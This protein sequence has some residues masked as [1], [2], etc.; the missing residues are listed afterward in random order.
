MEGGM[1]GWHGSCPS[2]D[3]ASVQ[4]SKARQASARQL[5]IADEGS[6]RSGKDRASGTHPLGRRQGILAAGA[7]GRFPDRTT[8]LYNYIH[9]HLQVSMFTGSVYVHGQCLCSHPSSTAPL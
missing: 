7:G 8:L 5:R 1:G 3:R 4:V 9:T 2:K 6:A